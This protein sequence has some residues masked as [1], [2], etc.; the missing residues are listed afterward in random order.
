MMGNKVMM[1]ALSGRILSPKLKA[2]GGNQGLENAVELLLA[3][4]SPLCLS[5]I[6]EGKNQC[7]I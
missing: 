3:Y 4:Q 5:S 7:Q 1:M 2:P 6:R